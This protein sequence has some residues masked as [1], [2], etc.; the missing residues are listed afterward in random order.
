[1]LALSATAAADHLVIGRDEACDVVL[2]REGVS[3]RHARLSFS[4]DVWMIQDLQSTN[5]TYVNQV[6]VGRCRLEPGD[7]VVFGDEPVLID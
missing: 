1:M 4:G 6:R 2:S 3:R 5:G 7:C